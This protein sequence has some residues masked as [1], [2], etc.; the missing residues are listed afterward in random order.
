MKRHTLIDFHGLEVQ[1]G[2]VECQL[3]MFFVV[4][5]KAQQMPVFFCLVIVR[6]HNSGN[7]TS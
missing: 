7:L 1:D 2:I 3:L 4:I 5:V 6:H